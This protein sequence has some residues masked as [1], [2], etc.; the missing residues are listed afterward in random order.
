MY[1]LNG[2]RRFYKFQIKR[3]NKHNHALIGDIIIVINRL[4]LESNYEQV[5]VIV[6]IKLINQNNV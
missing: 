6:N 3:L 5:K 1:G 4:R 2:G